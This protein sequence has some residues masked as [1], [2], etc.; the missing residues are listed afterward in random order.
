M[1]MKKEFRIIYTSD[2]HGRLFAERGE[3]GL[4]QTAG[5]FQKDGN[6]MIFDGGDLLQGGST[7]AFLVQRFQER[8]D[9]SFGHPAGLLMNVCGYDA[10]TLGNHD[11]NY[12][13]P[14]LASYLQAF[15]GKCLC[16]NICDRSGILPIQDKNVFVLENGLRIGVFGLCTD[17]LQGWEKEE[18]LQQLIVEDPLLAAY[19][20]VKE[21]R[22]Q[23]DLV[24][25]IYHGGFEENLETGEIC[26]FSGENI[27]CELCRELEI[28]VLLTGHQHVKVE[29]CEICGTCVVQPGCFG[30]C[31]AEIAGVLDAHGSLQISSRLVEA[32]VCEARVEAF[33]NYF[34]ELQKELNQW[35]RKVICRLPRPIPIDD[36]ITMALWGSELADLIN[37]VQLEVTGAHISA[38]CLSNAAVGLPEEVCIEDVYRTYTS[39]NTLCVV[40][41]DGKT[42]RQAIEWT[43]EFLQ[44]EKGIYRIDERFLIPKVKYFHYDF[45]AGIDYS[46]DYT[47]PA[48]QRILHLKFNGKE[49]YQEDVFRLCITNYRYA[50]GEGYEMFRKCRLV[51]ADSL[52]MSEHVICYLK[53]H[54][55]R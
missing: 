28:D 30:Q 42:L 37:R 12:G 10:V 43:A 18:T 9:G 32:P 14:Y 44:C 23:S 34:A 13:I 4:D 48:G 55:S 3:N 50:G 35:K 24:V 17:A 6:T 21:L 19:R 20:I 45:Y 5:K 53:T 25:C 7:G 46:I 22:A 29:H 47:R 52:P 31:Y 51:E 49:I 16:A 38:T 39:A 33:E 54:G 41:C 1:I 26:D 11:F 15:H 27:A 8:E 40:E 2:V 36:R